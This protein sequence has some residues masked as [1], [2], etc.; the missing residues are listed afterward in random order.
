MALEIETLLLGPLETN[1][2]VV[3]ACAKSLQTPD[4]ATRDVCWVVDPGM[5]PQ[6]LLDHLRRASAKPS[7]ILL[8]HG[9]CDHV[10][11]VG[12]LRE[13]FPAARLLCPAGDAEMLADAQANLSA[14]FGLPMI[15]PEADELIEAG[16]MLLL[17]ATEWQILDTSG[18]TPGG[19]SFYCAAENVVITGDALFAGGIGRIDIPGASCEKLL[20]NIRENLLALPDQTRV[21]PGHGPSTTIG[22]E[23]QTNPFVLGR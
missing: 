5:W 4:A 18:H 17:G 15:A 22:H 1:C 11:G 12:E 10:A 7:A 13:H 3:R 6:P 2:Y 23:R 9:H 20:K 14:P 16:Q 8:T 19:V 21:L